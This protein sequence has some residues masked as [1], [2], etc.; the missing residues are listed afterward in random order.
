MRKILRILFILLVSLIGLF[1]CE[2]DYLQEELCSDIPEANTEM[3]T[4]RS[5]EERGFPEQKR[6]VLGEK[7]KNPYSV[8]NMQYAFDYYNLNIKNSPFVGKKVNP[9]HFY[10]KLLPE[11]EKQLEFL[12]NLELNHSND[13]IVLHDYPLDYEIVEDGDYFVDP[14]NENDLYQ[15]TYTVIPVDYD[16]DNNIPFQII[17]KLYKPTEDEYVVET[18]SLVFA[19]WREDLKAD[20][21]GDVTKSN[22]LKYLKGL[23]SNVNTSRWCV[24]GCRYRP[25][26]NV[27]IENTQTNSITEPLM[28][29]KISIGRVFWWRYTYTDN[30]GHFVSPKKYRGKVWIRAKWRSRVA[31]IKKSWNE[32]LGISVSDYLMTI[33]RSNNNRTRYILSYNKH[34]WYKGTVHNGIVKYNQYA[35]SHGIYKRV[36]N[37]N[38]WVWENGEDSSTPMLYQYRNLPTLAYIAGV[39]QFN[40]WGSLTSSLIRIVPSHLRPDHIYGGLKN[41]TY[42]NEVNTAKIE[43]LV[44]H[45]S[46]HFSHAKNA[47]SFF[48]ANLFASEIGNSIVHDDSYHNGTKPTNRAGQ[49]IALA[50]G[51]ATAVE[52]RATE[53]YYG[54]AW[55]GDT[56]TS[57]PL[58]YME[59]FDMYTR[60]MTAVERDDNHSW[61]LSGVILDCLDNNVDNTS[62][63]LINGGNNNIIN[64]INDHVNL[65]TYSM[66]PIFRELKS[67]THTGYDLR[68]KLAVDYSSQAEEINNL[69]ISYGY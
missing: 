23:A 5:V 21:L 9:T 3:L 63:H 13:S 29:E 67:S 8:K 40:F 44:F 37:A 55:D 54:I 24:F 30:N 20:G 64:S 53:H 4:D 60:P 39:S 17:D 56:M 35:S 69:F 52:F 31:T 18:V 50:E 43:Q 14:K 32:L 15:P 42:S 16:F 2:E 62:I 28:Q 19:D 25:E 7:L 48:W 1:S 51:W 34:L 46:A 58:G 66:F 68:K 36:Y 26:G 65:G 61:F 33:K 10:V 27:K 12:D 6:I 11:N 22:L 41:K 59:T 45:E 38:V 49:R 57:Y 47:G